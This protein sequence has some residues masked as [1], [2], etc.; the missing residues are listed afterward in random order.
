MNVDRGPRISI[1][2]PLRDEVDNV[3]VLWSELRDVL[4][5]IR[6]TAEVVF[7]DDGSSDGTDEAIR[8]VR[9]SD[10]RVRCI[11]LR[12]GGGLTAA[13]MA[14]FGATTGDVIVTLD[15]DLQNDPH[16]IPAMLAELEHADAVVGWRETRRDTLVKR[17]ASRIAN[18]VRRRL[19]GDRFHDSACS[20]RVMSRRCLSALPPYDGMHR[21]VPIL[22][23]MNGYTVVETPVAHRPRSHGLSKFGIRDRAA[24]ALIDCL[25]V[26]WMRTRMIAGT[27]EI[28]R[29]AEGES[30][31]GSDLSSTTKAR[32][33]A[34]SMITS[35]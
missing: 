24:R 7:V 27:A 25:V 10:S 21:F 19:L 26:R 22:L 14:G 34:P 20:L 28:S 31:V 30:D 18:A 1:V 3:P 2:I 35:L 9:Q 16:D 33:P 29:G 5:T 15:G 12:G 6:D 17:V 8:R 4:A 23:T 11:R 32:T 13:F